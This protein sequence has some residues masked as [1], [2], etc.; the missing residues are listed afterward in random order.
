M[1]QV[2][3]IIFLLV[4]LMFVVSS[5]SMAQ[6]VHGLE[7]SLYGGRVIPHRLGMEALARNT[8]G[9][10]FNYYFQTSSD[11]FYDVKYRF[12]LHG[13]GVSYDYLGNPDVLGSAYSVYS[14]MDFN[15]FDREHF[16]ISFRTN[17]GLAYL[18]QKYDRVTNVDNIAISTNLCFYFNISFGFAYKFTS[19]Y[20]LK[21]S[22]GFLHYSNGAVHK[23]N[24]G[25][26][27]AFVS[28]SLS[29]DVATKDIKRTRTDY[30]D[31]L[32]PHEAWIMG[33]CVSSDE[34]S[35]GY[36]GRG[37]GFICSTIAAGYN[38]QYGK[39]GKVGLSFD[40]FYNENLKYYYSE[41]SDELVQRYDKFSDVMR[42]GISVGHQLIYKRFELVAFVGTYIYNKAKPGDYLYTRIGGRYYFT[43]FMF[44]NL[45]LKAKGFKAQFIE[46][47]IGFSC[48]KWS[49][50]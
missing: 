4:V 45:S 14:F 37:G 3:R 44:V 26:N 36:E 34:Y 25:L 38:F 32:S 40:M 31:G 18:T 15:L 11:N 50:K 20:E 23:P 28:L 43:N 22:P 8:V 41:S 49:A 10:E 48:R 21:L 2:R 9:G 17:A 47:G 39:I 27:Q 12:P 16:K 19:G 42:F 1:R 33:T 46:C 6:R 35:K 29:K 13:F 5:E 24:L 7:F 30:Q